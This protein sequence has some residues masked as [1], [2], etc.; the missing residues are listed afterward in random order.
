MTVI[1]VILDERWLAALG[2][3]CP[4]SQLACPLQ[5]YLQLVAHLQLL[6]PHRSYLMAPESSDNAVEGDRSLGM[7]LL[8]LQT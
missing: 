8:N 4:P 5:L 6:Q 1:L 2:I 3:V 7:L